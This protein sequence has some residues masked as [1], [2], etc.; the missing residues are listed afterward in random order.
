M[1]RYSLA[2]TGE[3]AVH[4]FGNMEKNPA[5]HPSLFVSWY[6]D[7]W[8]CQ[9]QLDKNKCDGSFNLRM[10]SPKSSWFKQ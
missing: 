5:E 3:N 10:F 2:I 9:Y 6:Y 8:H 1:A 4:L 7:Q